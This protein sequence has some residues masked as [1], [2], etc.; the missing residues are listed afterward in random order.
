MSRE[1]VEIIRWI[2][3]EW[4]TGNLRAGID[5]YDRWVL[6][7][8]LEDLPYADPQLGAESVKQW[9]RRW[10]EGWANFTIAADELID[11]GDSVVVGVRQRAEGHESGTPAEI[12]YFE[13]WTFRGGKVIS[14]EQFRE[15]GEALEAV[16]LR[17]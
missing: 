4:R 10:L 14:R 3:S 9:M 11:A 12:R 6:F 1:N 17:E 16:G 5:L 7:I 2:D 8:P 15:R 13:V